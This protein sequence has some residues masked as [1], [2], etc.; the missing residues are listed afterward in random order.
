MTP[1]GWIRAGT[2]DAFQLM[3]LE[4]WSGAAVAERLE[5]KIARV[6][7]ARSEVKEMIRQEARKIERLE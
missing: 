6:D 1:S 7:G 5:M 2:R 4:A 3:A